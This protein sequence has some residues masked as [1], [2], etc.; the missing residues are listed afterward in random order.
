MEI[1][2]DLKS[3][4]YNYSQKIESNKYTHRIQD[5]SENIKPKEY[6]VK[7]NFKSFYELILSI[8][9]NQYQILENSEKDKYVSELLPSIKEKLGLSI[10]NKKYPSD[11]ILI[12]ADLLLK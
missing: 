9:D 10:P 8:K 7:N 2:N 1:F 5:K 6:D 12:C 4:N 3:K 11:H